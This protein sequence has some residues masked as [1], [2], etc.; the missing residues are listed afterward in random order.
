M[1]TSGEAAEVNADEPAHVARELAVFDAATLPPGVLVRTTTP[2]DATSSA[3]AFLSTLY[4][5]SSTMTLEHEARLINHYGWET[6]ISELTVAQTSGPEEHAF[7]VVIPVGP[8][9]AFF[10]ATMAADDRLFA[11]KRDAIFAFASHAIPAWMGGATLEDYVWL[12][13]ATRRENATPRLCRREDFAGWSRRRDAPFGVEFHRIEA[14]Q[15]GVVRVH[16]PSRPPIPAARI[17]RTALAEARRTSPAARIVAGTL[18]HTTNGD[19]FVVFTLTDPTDKNAFERRIGV[20]YTDRAMAVI[21]GSFD[22]AAAEPFRDFVDVVTQDFP[23]RDS[24]RVRVRRYVHAKPASWA[25]RVIDLT[26]YLIAPGAVAT[27]EV[28]PA[29]PRGTTSIAQRFIYE[30]ANIVV[31]PGLEERVI[32]TTAGLSGK[33]LLSP[34]RHG[35]GATEL[36]VGGAL[37]LDDAFEYMVRYRAEGSAYENLQAQFLAVV[38]SVQPIARAQPAVVLPETITTYW[39]N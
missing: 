33:V 38:E 8:K 19:D 22:P 15:A 25:T 34:P 26:S 35:S 29:Q 5:A 16:F 11:A 23:M 10:V 24:G 21:D 31:Q 17:A 20:V 37:L 30:D 32:T 36:R 13:N 39:T 9:A 2:R 27:I 3:K 4:D 18:G 1:N 6:I 12:P 7:V 14:P 28:L